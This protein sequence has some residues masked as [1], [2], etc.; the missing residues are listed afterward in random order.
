MAQIARLRQPLPD[1]QAGSGV[2]AVEDVVRRLGPAREAADAVELTQRREPL[3][4]SGQ[5][6]VRVGLVAGIPDDS[7]AR[8]L[9]QPVEGDRQLDDAE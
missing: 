6:L 8:R 9:Q 2:T 4:A 3:Q 7:I 1:G 5:Q